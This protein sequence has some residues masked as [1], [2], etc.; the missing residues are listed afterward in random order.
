M[1][2]PSASTTPQATAVASAV[3][4]GDGIGPE[5]MEA[6]LT[7]LTEAGAAIEPRPIEIGERI[8]R[9]GIT[10][11][12]TDESLELLSAT[13]VLLKAPI[14]TPQGGGYKSLNVTIR[15][16]FGLYANVRPCRSLAPFVPTLHPTMDVVVI[17]EN[18]EDVY[19]GIEHRQTRDV[20]QCLK[21]ITRSGSERVVRYAFEYARANG[22]RLV[23]CFTK[24]NIMKITDGL[25]HEVFREIAREYPEIE[26]EHLIVDIGAA[27]LATNPERFDVIVLPNLYG[28]ILSDVAAE[29]C[30]SVGMAGS[31]NIGERFAMF[32]AIHG[33]APDI[34]GTGTANPS[35]LLDAAVTMLTQIGQP[36]VAALVRNAWLKTLEDGLHTRDIF[37]PQ[38]KRCLSTREF[39]LSVIERLGSE[40]S[41]LHAPPLPAGAVPVRTCLEPQAPAA[42]PVKTRLGVDVF[43]DW[44]AAGDAEQLARELGAVGVPLTLE[45]ITNRGTQVWSR[46]STLTRCVDHWRCRFVGKGEVSGADVMRT[47]TEL[48]RAGFDVIKSEGLYAFDGTPGFSRGQGQ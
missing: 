12:I 20:T 9:S 37:G 46:A 14:T 13:G 21:L 8:Y 29:L 44:N 6:V 32:E 15:K 31:A 23:T 41:V 47:L 33:S 36:N 48:D 11:G 45:M 40:P 43:L 26:N 30:G 27:K 2:T 18:E 1:S 25:F 10:S 28:D 19:G 38:S 4:H 39:A 17:R 22:R 35:G 42:L 34:A 16:M 24:D 3:A 7:I 5:I